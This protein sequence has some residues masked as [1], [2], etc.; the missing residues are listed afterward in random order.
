MRMCVPSHCHV[1]PPDI[2][3][4]EPA[5]HSPYLTTSDIYRTNIVLG[6]KKLTLNYLCFHLACLSHCCCTALEHVSRC[7]KSLL[8]PPFLFSFLLC[9]CLPPILLCILPLYLALPPP[10][11]LL[12]PSL[13]SPSYFPAIPTPSSSYLSLK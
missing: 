4:C 6:V 10:T 1:F 5:V 8:L 11:C 2:C 9:P 7:I 13:A 3:S 12:P